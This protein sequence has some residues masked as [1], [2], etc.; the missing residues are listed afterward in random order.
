MV[1]FYLKTLEKT[2]VVPPIF[3]NEKCI[4]EIKDKSN[5]LIF[6]DNQYFMNSNSS[7][8]P[9]EINEVTEEILEYITFNEN[10]SMTILNAL[11]VKKKQGT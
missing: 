5:Y 11:E 8:L 2:S 4:T 10:D 3:I 6:F 1:F 9:K 7:F